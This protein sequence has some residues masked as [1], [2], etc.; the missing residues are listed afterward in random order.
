MD[1]EGRSLKAQMRSAN[2]S[3]ARYALLIGP[4]E[5]DRGMVKLKDMKEG[6]ERVVSIEEAR[7]ALQGGKK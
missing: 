1:F 3:G 4:E 2:K 6:A 5:A 7:A